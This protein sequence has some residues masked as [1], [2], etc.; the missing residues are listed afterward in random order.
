M[1]A[2]RPLR[3]GTELAG[4][5]RYRDDVW[6]LGPAQLQKHLVGKV[7]DF[8]TLP[9]AYRVTAKQLFY[10]VLA[11]P[12]PEGERML[13]PVT[14]RVAFTKLKIFTA[15]LASR[16]SPPLAKVTPDDVDAYRRAQAARQVSDS[17]LFGLQQAIRQ[18]WAHRDVLD[19]HLR[20][21]PIGLDGWYAGRTI[22]GRS[23]ENSTDRIPEV[24]LGPLLDGRCGSSTNCRSTSWP[25]VANGPSCMR[26]TSPAGKDAAQEKRPRRRRP[27]RCWNA[28]GRPGGHCP[29]SPWAAAPAARPE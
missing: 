4:T 18:L 20:F 23:R 13:G 12:W 29:A 25:L 15:W 27:W 26:G 2:G 8:T 5:S 6:D 22:Y 24:V 16:G 10:A 7:L 17:W 14:I 1:L 3:P 21:D 28:T 11:G 19:D 9:A